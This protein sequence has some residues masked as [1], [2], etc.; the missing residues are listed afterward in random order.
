M[1]AKTPIL[2]LILPMLR[3]GM[4]WTALIQ[5]LQ[6]ISRVSVLDCQQMVSI[7]TEL[8]VVCI[9]ASQF[10]S[11]LTIYPPPNKYLRQGFI[12]LALFI[13]GPKES[14]KQINIF[15][16]LLM[17]E[18]KELWQGLD[19]YDSYLKCRFNLCATYLWLIHDF[20]AYGKFVGWC[21][22]G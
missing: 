7:L 11:C 12:I 18:R 15:L 2:C 14:N 20:L 13:L 10:L 4:P 1:I 22:H 16:C 5:N 8:I 17:E 6:G 19:A 21:V 3:L 9:H